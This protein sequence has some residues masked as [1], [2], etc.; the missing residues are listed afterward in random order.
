[1][2]GRVQEDVIAGLE[3]QISSPELGVEVAFVTFL[4]R[5]EA[6][7]SFLD[8]LFKLFEE[9]VPVLPIHSWSLPDRFVKEER[10]RRSAKNEL[11]G[12]GAGA[13]VHIFVVSVGQM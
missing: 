8:R 10:G 12:W 11:K 1:M 7:M 6:S 3:I 5:I 2:E 4:G 13:P 9:L